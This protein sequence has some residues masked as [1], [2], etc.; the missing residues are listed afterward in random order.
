M[1]N[2]NLMWIQ[3]HSNPNI[4]T[5]ISRSIKLFEMKV[6]QDIKWLLRTTPLIVLSFY[7]PVYIHSGLTLEGDSGEEV[8]LWLLTSLCT[9]AKREVDSRHQTPNKWNETIPTLF[10]QVRIRSTVFIFVIVS[11]TS[12][13]NGGLKNGNF[14]VKIYRFFNS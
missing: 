2:Q 12:L 8:A 13:Y 14:V 5:Y 6:T 7:L 9:S 10:S 1:Y 3:F 4:A 11:I